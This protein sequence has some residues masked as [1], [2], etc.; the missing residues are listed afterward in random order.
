MKRTNQ[1]RRQRISHGNEISNSP[2]KLLSPLKET[3]WY[4]LFVFLLFSIGT[5]YKLN[6]KNFPNHNDQRGCKPTFDLLFPPWRIQIGVTIFNTKLGIFQS[7]FWEGLRI[8]IW[9]F[10]GGWKWKMACKSSNSIKHWTRKFLT[11]FLKSK[12][13]HYREIWSNENKPM[14]GNC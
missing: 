13:T 12:L 14:F 8:I 5:K 1:I 2:K 11:A 9:I 3:F 6:N 10:D 4:S 7:F